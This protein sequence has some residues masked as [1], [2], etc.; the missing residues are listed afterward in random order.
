[1]LVPSQIPAH[2]PTRIPLCFFVLYMLFCTF[3]SASC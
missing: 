2:H 3:F 1:M